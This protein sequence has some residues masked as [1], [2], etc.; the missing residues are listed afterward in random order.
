MAVDAQVTSSADNTAL[1]MS[2]ISER[3]NY[4]C[5]RNK[6]SRQSIRPPTRLSVNSM[7]SSAVGAHILTV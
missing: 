4:V 7:G 3:D 5:S 2:L 1:S 6:L